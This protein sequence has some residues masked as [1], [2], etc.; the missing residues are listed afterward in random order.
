MSKTL[1]VI[2]YVAIYAFVSA[3]FLVM[4]IYFKLEDG[5]S[6]NISEF[7]ADIPGA[8]TMGLTPV[9]IPIVF[10]YLMLR[11]KKTTGESA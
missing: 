9:L 10:Y 6:Y 2:I 5:H 4:K 8:L 11:R 7:K 1:R 3:G